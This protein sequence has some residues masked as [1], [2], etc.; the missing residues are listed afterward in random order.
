MFPREAEMV[1]DLTGLQGRE[2]QNALN[3]LED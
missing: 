3:N 2:M 1:F